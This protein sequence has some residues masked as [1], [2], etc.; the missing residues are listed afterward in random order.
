MYYESSTS[1]KKRDEDGKIVV[2][3]NGNLKIGDNSRSSSFK[4]TRQQL[5]QEKD[6][7]IGVAMVL[8]ANFGPSAIVGELKLSNKEVHVFNSYCEQNKDCAQFN[9]QS[10]LD[11]QRKRFV[12]FRRKKFLASHS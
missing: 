9:L 3:G 8:N 4:Y 2:E 12:S 6:G 10:I 1:Y 7:E 11:V 5:T